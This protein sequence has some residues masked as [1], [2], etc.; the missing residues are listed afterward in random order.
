[1]GPG[2]RQARQGGARDELLPGGR[3]VRVRRMLA[4]SA[5]VAGDRVTAWRLSRPQALQWTT[6]QCWGGVASRISDIRGCLLCW[7]ARLGGHG[8]D[9]LG[10]VRVAERRPVA[11]RPRFGELGCPSLRGQPARCPAQVLVLVLVQQPGGRE[12]LCFPGPAGR[13]S[14]D[15]G[16][17]LGGVEDQAGNGKELSVA[18]GGIARRSRLVVAIPVA[19]ARPRDAITGSPDDR[20]DTAFSQVQ[21]GPGVDAHPAGRLGRP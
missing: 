5:T 8:D 13:R 9:E 21:G 17:V 1:M 11:V 15:L 6:G 20:R 16:L 3:A 19:D 12:L 4:G 2:G 10:V 7:R 18:A 14:R